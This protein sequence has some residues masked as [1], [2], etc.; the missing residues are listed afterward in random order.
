M[1]LCASKNVETLPTPDECKTGDTSASSDKTACTDSVA[2]QLPT[3]A[4]LMPPAPPTKTRA[5]IFTDAGADL[6]D[7]MALLLAK[8]LIDADQLTLEAVVCTLHPARRR[9]QLVRGTLDALGLGDVP[10]VIGSDGGDTDRQQTAP[11]PSDY[12]YVPA[13]EDERCKSLEGLAFLESVLTNA[14]PKSLSIVILAS[15]KDASSLLE[16]HE[17]LFVDRVRDVTIMGGVKW[18]ITQYAVPDSAH[19]N[20]FDTGA[21]AF[22]Y[23]RCQELRVPLIIVGRDACYE[24]PA[25]QDIYEQLGQTGSQMGSRL[26]DAAHSTIDD[27]RRRASASGAER[28][29]L[30]ARCDATWFADT[31]CHG[32]PDVLI[33]P[34]RE[35]VW[36]LVVSFNL[37]DV[38][39]LAL[40]IPALRAAFVHPDCAVS[41]NQC[42]HA[43][44]GCGEGAPAFR[45][46]RAR[47]ACAHLVTRGPLAGHATRCSSNDIPALRGGAHSAALVMAEGRLQLAG[48]ALFSEVLREA[49]G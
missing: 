19:N 43:F 36:D 31:F 33:R 6:D 37:Y 3:P 26:R 44:V 2:S 46:A 34:A 45:S 40:S 20:S 11:D 16:R 14:A 12:A 22:F 39:A 8:A 32:N 5:I 29:G 23:E 4:P 1:G 28:R 18:P 10:V 21:S 30:P 25:P 27:L 38:V 7:E 24:V 48:A 15:L 47:A 42:Q 41:I 13:D 9:A 17:Q 35:S 49:R